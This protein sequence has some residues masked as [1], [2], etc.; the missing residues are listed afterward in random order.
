MTSKDIESQHGK[1]FEQIRHDNMSEVSQR[2][3]RIMHRQCC[4]Y[5]GGI[6]V[7]HRVGG[8]EGTDRVQ[9][10]C[11]SVIHR[12]GGLEALDAPLYGVCG[13]IHRVGGLEAS[14][15]RACAVGSVIH[16][17]ALRPYAR[18]CGNAASRSASSSGPAGRR[19]GYGGSI[20][21]F[22]Q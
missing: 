3:A 5:P 17:V 2:I 10:P 6:Q 13:V 11:S 18:R 12:V 20:G 9:N 7:I 8:L 1:T 19:A 16:R 14:A 4:Q 15:P 21:P 22:R